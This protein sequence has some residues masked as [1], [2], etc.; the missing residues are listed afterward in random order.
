V[1]LTR[2]NLAAVR[3]AMREYDEQ[4]CIKPDVILVPPELE[5]EVFAIHGWLIFQDV[6]VAHRVPK[7]IARLVAR[8]WLKKHKDELI[9]AGRLLDW[10]GQ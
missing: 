7:W 2:K 3:D 8:R 4:Y 9:L 6:L 1:E 10:G 5:V